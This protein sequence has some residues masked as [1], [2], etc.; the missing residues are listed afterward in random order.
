MA[1]QLPIATDNAA[2]AGTTLHYL[3]AGPFGPTTVLL[4]HG[5]RFTSETCASSAQS[6]R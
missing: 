5:A 4:L 2:I 6:P 3:E 1:A